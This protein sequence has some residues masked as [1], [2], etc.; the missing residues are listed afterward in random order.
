MGVL[1]RLIGKDHFGP[2]VEHAKKVQ[3][4]VQLVEPL[5]EAWLEEDWAT[6]G[7]M[8]EEIS[9]LEHEADHLKHQY[10]Q[11]L[12]KKV[13]LP[14]PRGD[15]MRIL[16]EADNIADE[17]EHY[18]ILLSLRKII[19]PDELK[20]LMREFL[21]PVL[22]A[23]TKLLSATESLGVLKEASFS[24]PESERILA[25]VDE[26]SRLEWQCKQIWR[27]IAKLILADET[28]MNPLDVLMGMRVV[29]SLSELAN[30]AENC[31][32]N[33]RHLILSAKK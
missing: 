3:S 19:L 21:S 25:T 30:H 28:G 15:L 26:I 4:C 22:E 32:D 31:G 9:K 10:R 24:G 18:A 6:L 29:G 16:H 8:N 7:K 12:P 1:D 2:L 27:K 14:V 11:N 5:T 20:A 17:V 13:F 23:N 33:L